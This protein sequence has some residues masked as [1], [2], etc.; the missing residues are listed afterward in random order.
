MTRMPLCIPSSQ[1]NGCKT[2]YSIIPYVSL[3]VSIV[4]TPSIHS[5]CHCSTPL[6][7]FTTTVSSPSSFQL[8]TTTTASLF[9][10]PSKLTTPYF[11][12]NHHPR[13]NPHLPSYT[14]HPQP[15]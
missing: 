6:T 2:P 15:S 14:H 11:C 5:L 13:R 8:E 10:S 1:G 12:Q 4:P 9:L 7:T 3:P